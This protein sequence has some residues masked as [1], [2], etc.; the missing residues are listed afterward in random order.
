MNVMLTRDT[1]EEMETQATSK[2]APT[3]HAP[4]YPRRKEESWWLVI[5]DTRTSTLLSVKRVP[6]GTT[7]NVKLE[8]E[9]PEG[10]TVMEHKLKLY[11][12]SD[13]YLGCDQ[14]NDFVLK[15]LPSTS[16]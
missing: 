11:L 9:A 13:S 8:F 7:A 14:E 4:F 10:D 15:V 6:L 2:K 3:V 1:E 5:G 12:M 16:E